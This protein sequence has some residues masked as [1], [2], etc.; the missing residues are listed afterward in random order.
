MVPSSSINRAIGTIRGRLELNRLEVRVYTVRVIS[1][2][3]CGI[4]EAVALVRI[5]DGVDGTVAR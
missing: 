5:V 3:R 2:I 1:I 4:H